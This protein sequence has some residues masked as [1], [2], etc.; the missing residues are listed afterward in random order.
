MV[1]LVALLL[2]LGVVV[3][4]VARHL[5][6]AG[7]WAWMKE[8]YASWDARG[9]LADMRSESARLAEPTADTSDIYVDDILRMAEPGQAYHRPVDLRQMVGKAR[10]R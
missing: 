8:S 10:A 6:D 2:A 1:S 7:F 3:I 9:E 5:P 4:L